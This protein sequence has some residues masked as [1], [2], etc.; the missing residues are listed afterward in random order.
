MPN[1]DK[2]ASSCHPST[3]PFKLEPHSQK[4]LQFCS[5]VS[6]SFTEDKARSLSLQV[7]FQATDLCSVFV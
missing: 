5:N 6:L 4:S 7:T 3:N 2:K 1:R